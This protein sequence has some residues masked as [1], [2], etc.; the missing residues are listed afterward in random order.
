MN[1]KFNLKANNFIKNMLRYSYLIIMALLLN[2]VV[3]EIIVSANKIISVNIDYM[4]SGEAVDIGSIIEKFIYLTLSGFVLSFAGSRL[5]LKYAVRV[6][7]SYRKQI[8]SKLYRIDYS[9]YD[10]AG[11][12]TIINKVNSDIAEAENFLTEHFATIITNITAALIYANYVR[13]INVVLFVA[14]VVSYPLVIWLSNILVKKM[15]DV[16]K[17]YRLKVDAMLGIDHEAIMGYQI[18]KAFGLQKYFENRM[19][20]ASEELVETEQIRT[21]IS[22]TAIVIR[23]LIQWIPSILCAFLSIWL[24]RNGQLTV[25]EL[26]GFVVILEK[27]V[28]SIIGIPFAIVDATGCMVCIGR[29]EGILSAKDEHFGDKTYKATNIDNSVSDENVLDEDYVIEFDNIKFAYKEDENVLND[30]SFKIKK[31]ENIAIVGSSGGGKTTIFRLLCGLYHASDG[32]YKLYGMDINEWNIESARENMALVS[33]NTFLFPGTIEENIRY[34]NINATHD[35]VVNACKDARIHDFIEGLADGYK[36]VIS[37]GGSQLSG[38]QRQR[39]AIARAILKNTPILL[40]DEPTSAI[41]E[42]TEQLIQDALDRLCKGKTSITIAHRLSTIEDHA[43]TYKG[44][45][46]VIRRNTGTVKVSPDETSAV[47]STS[48]AAVDGMPDGY[49]PGESVAPES[50]AAATT[51]AGSSGTSAATASTGGSETKG[52]HSETT[53][54]STTAAATEAATTAAPATEATTAAAP[55]G[56][57][58]ETTA[59]ATTEAVGN[60]AGFPGN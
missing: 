31:G 32:T 41:D 42:G 22:N 56:P 54:A 1:Q 53:A 47:E 48:A 30:V 50:S 49:V 17:V 44:H 16:S 36:T 43:K 58:D 38:G 25:G 14:V 60:I 8:S 6:I 51:A 27:F 11:T 9:Y 34:G 24:V 7:N 13:R 35:E 19:H 59:A 57:G 20:N 46:A 23:R 2:A 37:E 4:L 55:N 29:L 33:Q 12:A 45:A 40:L 10:N 28:E 26:V 5:S 3:N 52:T 39:I 21:G 15:R 18:I